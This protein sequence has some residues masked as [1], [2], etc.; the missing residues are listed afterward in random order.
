MDIIHSELCITGSVRKKCK[1]CKNRYFRE[2]YRNRVREKD[3]KI[4]K[5]RKAI[6]KK[7]SVS[8]DI[9]CTDCKLKDK[10]IKDFCPDCSSKYVSAINRKYYSAKKQKLS[11]KCDQS[12][13]NQPNQIELIRPIC[14][15][16][17]NGGS[18][19]GGND[20]VGSVGSGGNENVGSGGGGLTY[21]LHQISQQ[22]T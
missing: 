18:D 20:K 17:G 1:D 13:S 5:T 16:S 14:G 4:I 11:A 2:Q 22:F 6:I 19:S 7:R 15:V 12:Q 3:E 10:T 9:L 8:S 21:F